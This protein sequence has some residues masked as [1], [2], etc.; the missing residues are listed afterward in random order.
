VDLSDMRKLLILILL[1]ASLPAFAENHEIGLTIGGLL[2]QDRGVSPNAVRLGSGTAL[3]ANYGQKLIDGRAEL[4]GEVHFLGNTQRIVTSANPASARDV[5]TIYITPGIRVKFT[6][7]S[8]LS[9]YLAVGG[10]VAFYQQSLLQIDGRPNT[11]PRNT[12]SGVF[13]FGGGV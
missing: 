9:P 5:A 10:G 7:K 11:A 12:S 3:Q 1:C 8:R 4:F 2:P 13:E 6:P